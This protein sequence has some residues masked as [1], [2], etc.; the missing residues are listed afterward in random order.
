[1]EQ[2][3]PI[4]GFY[5]FGKEIALAGTRED[6]AFLARAVVC[7]EQRKRFFF[8][9]PPNDNSYPYE[10]FLWEMQIVNTEKL[11][12]IYLENNVLMITG[13]VRGRQIMA[14]ELLHFSEVPFENDSALL[15]QFKMHHY[16]NH[17]YLDPTSIGLT[18]NIIDMSWGDFF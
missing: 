1:M 12:R 14:H 16:P 3:I 5:T 4:T 13:S 18:I 8:Y 15:K 7:H 2:R 17:P 11:I 10:G 6:L 9:I